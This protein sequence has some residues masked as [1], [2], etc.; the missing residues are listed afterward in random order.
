MSQHLKY[1]LIIQLLLSTWIL[2][3]QRRALPSLGMVESMEQDRVLHAAGYQGLVLSISTYLSPRKVS[4]IQFE[5]NLAR[6]RRLALPVWAFNI[7]IP[8]EL[9]LVGPEVNEAALL[10]YADTVIQRVSLTGAKLIVL[11][12]GGA[13]RLPPGFDPL[14][15]RHQFIQIGQK[16]ADLAS[17]YDL[18]IALEA[19]NRS[20]TNFINTLGEA[21]SIVKKIN[22]PHFRLNV[23]LYHLL[24]EQESPQVIRRC[25]KYVVYA[26]LAEPTHRTAPGVEGTDFAPYLKALAKLRYHGHLV[27][28]GRWEDLSLVAGPSYRYLLQ[29]VSLAYAHQHQ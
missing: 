28:E 18:V 3:G 24:K 27:V 10:G 5:E 16:L 6:L 13:R 17:K 26:E 9:K 8:A 21:L 25:G 15:A 2:S 7:F 11:G 22:H 20:E 19:L 4:A 23:D 29:Q 12:S 14:T 1:V